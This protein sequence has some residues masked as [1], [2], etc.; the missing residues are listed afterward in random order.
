MFFSLDLKQYSLG[1]VLRN[2]FQ[3]IKQFWSLAFSKSKKII[4][5][6]FVEMGKSNFIWCYIYF[7]RTKTN[8]NKQNCF[9]FCF[10]ICFLFFY[11]FLFVKLTFFV[12]RMLVK[13]MLK[14]Y[15]QIK[16][17]VL[18]NLL[19]LIPLYKLR[20]LI[21]IPMMLRVYQVILKNWELMWP[22]LM[23]LNIQM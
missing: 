14:Q 16:K 15:F 19:L 2:V 10:F 4:F 3:S 20:E 9:V 7:S 18:Q 5:L 6:T 22:C 11:F 8:R 1:K 17:L 21:Y 12:F 23:V 13:Q